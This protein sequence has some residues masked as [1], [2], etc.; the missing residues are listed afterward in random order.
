MGLFQLLRALFAANFHRLPSDLDLDA[1]GVQFIITSGTSLYGH[2]VFSFVP[3][4]W[5]ASWKHREKRDRYQDL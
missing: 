3:H 5:V 2:G 1:V 4:A